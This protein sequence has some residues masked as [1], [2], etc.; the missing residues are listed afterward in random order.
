MPV[1]AQAC[2]TVVR[3]QFLAHARR[4]QG[5][6][7][8]VRAAGQQR[9]PPLDPGHGPARGIA[10]AG[11]R[12]QRPGFGQ[13]RAC[14]GVQ[15]RAQAQVAHIGEGALR[16]R[17]HDRFG[18]RLCQPG[19]LAQSQPQGR[20][21]AIVQASAP[22]PTFER[23]VPVAVGHV[24]RPHIDPG[25]PATPAPRILHDLAGRVE[26]HRLRIEQG[27]GECRRFVPLEPATDVDQ[28]GERGRVA[29]REAV[30]TEAL[31]LLQ[32]LLDEA[33]RIALPLHQLAD[34]RAV[35]LHVATTL[36]GRH[37]TPQRVG[38]VG[39]VAGMHHQLHHLLL[40]QRNPQG[41][42][43][44]LL[45]PFGGI[46]HR[47]PAHPPPQVGMD[48]AALD[49]A[50]PHDRHL[51]HQV[52]EARR[53]QARQHAHLRTRLDLEHAD[54]VGGLDH[55]VGGRVAG[56]DRGEVEPDATVPCDQVQRLADAGQHAQGQ[57]VDLEQAQ[58]LQVVLVPLDDGAPGHGRV[59]HRHQRR[60][61]CIG[62]HEAAHVLGQV[63]RLSLQ[64]PRQA[65]H[66]GDQRV[67]GIEAG[68]GQA[69]RHRRVAIAPAE[70][71]GQQAGLVR[72]QAEGPG[73]V[74]H[75]APAAV[76]DHR[77]GQGRALAAVLAI[78]VL[79]HL[80]AAFVLE[81]HVD[82]GRLLARA[83]Q[84]ARDQQPG[85]GRIDHGDAQRV[86]HRRVGR[87]TAPLAQDVARTGEAHDVV[88]GE[89]EGLVAQFGDQ[90]QF[91]LHLGPDLAWHAL[92]PALAQAGLG[93]C[94][95]VAGRGMPGRHQFDRIVV[96][97]LAQAETAAPRQF[98]R[99]LQQRRRMDVAQR[100]ARA[101]VALT[102]AE[103]QRPGL[104]QR[105]V[106]ADRDQ[107]VLEHAL[108]PARH[109]HIAAGQRRHAQLRGQRHQR[110]QA[111]GIVTLAMQFHRQIRAVAEYRLQPASLRRVGLRAGD[112][113]CEQAAAL[114]GT[115]L[116]LRPSVP[117]PPD[118]RLHIRPCQLVTLP[119]HAAS[120]HGDQ[121]AQARIAG[122]GL[123]QQHALQAIGQHEF[124]AH[125]QRH[126]GGLGGFQRAHDAGQRAFVG[127]RQRAVAAVAG[128]LEQGHRVAGPAQ[129]REIRQAVQLGVG[130]QAIVGA[131]RIL[132][133][134]I[135]V[136]RMQLQPLRQLPGPRR[137]RTG[138]GRIHRSH[139]F[140][141]AH[142][143][144]PCSIQPPCSPAGAN[145]QARWPC[146]VSST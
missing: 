79:Q 48:H 98:H 94:A 118:H 110:L 133:A 30:G 135:V 69:L 115:G 74:A 20:L 102:I 44:D 108:A 146:A 119:V 96:P 78:D 41:A 3:Q 15:A 105:G 126:A 33:G 129:E 130:R 112:P 127:D 32:D 97:E 65:Q 47:L 71:A 84:E 12:L 137:T 57:A 9:Q 116:V 68:L 61:R 143:N 86:A 23:V 55:R 121:F 142:A 64:H 16:A 38:L 46:V 50:R 93:Q 27:A 66:P 88:H 107:G 134:A 6:L 37:R 125:H 22:M 56:R 81:I 82:V 1:Q 139:R 106:V 11:Q 51:H 13:Q 99:G 91:L 31:D 89:E 72:R 63:A 39:A 77:G 87:G 101:Q 36:P 132:A 103:Q 14:P 28:L 90:A 109:V 111:R 21:P 136:G 42:A 67:G 4:R 95:Q 17:G 59:L 26:T 128:A 5:H 120:R 123:H 75:R 10:M 60:Q 124:A 53:P 144:Q 34:A 70:A 43:E 131:R 62:D 113:Q 85:L 52:V 29:L 92:R 54:G 138:R 40:E 49:R 18:R 80:F 83:G 140:I 117:R 7:G 100:P 73:H 122:M 104:R 58:R 2:G 25:P 19:H 45:H 8:L 141:P 114:P 145:A 76:A 35:R 24:H